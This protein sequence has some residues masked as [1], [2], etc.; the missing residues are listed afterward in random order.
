VGVAAI[1]G[2]AQ[3]YHLALTV[4]LGGDGGW[5]YIT[6]DTIGHRLF[7]ARSDRIMVVDPESGTL[8]G[9][10]PGLVR[11]HGVAFDYASGHGFATSGADSAVTM[12]DLRTLAVLGRTTAAVDDDAVLFDPATR[13]VFTMNGDAGSATVI[14]PLSGRRIGDVPLGGKP[15]FGVSD[16]A[17]KLYVNIE[18]SAQIVEVDARAMRVVRR[19]SIAPCTSPTGLAMDRAHRRLFSGCRGGVMAISDASAGRLVST[20]PI[21]QGVDAC[22]FD[23][24]AQLAFASNG[25]GTLT[26]IHE[27]TP[28]RYTVVANVATK[29]GARTMEID[30]RTRH[31]YTVTSDF[32]PAP[33]PVAGRR[34][35]RPPMV[36]GTFA[37]LILEP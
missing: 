30:L 31:I 5:D 35:P 2:R 33:A 13:R 19:W 10:I 18:D 3:S 6:L 21:G 12:F 32:G 24:G 17:G 16:G 37:L 25:D 36:P 7:I 27:D 20:V 23:P 14:D 9:T 8:L 34:P 11:G 26:V 28:D 29:Q 4:T 22:R 15:E 1:P